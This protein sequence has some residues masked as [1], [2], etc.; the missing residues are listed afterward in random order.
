LVIRKRPT[1]NI[2]MN[3][4]KNK[5]G[6]QDDRTI[7]GLGGGFPWEDLGSWALSEILVLLGELA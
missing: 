6:W 5:R 4:P 2:I 1:D 7:G 3:P